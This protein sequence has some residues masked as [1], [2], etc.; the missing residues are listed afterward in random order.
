MTRNTHARALEIIETDGTGCERKQMFRNI[1]L[2]RE[3]RKTI[4][5]LAEVI[6]R[7][8]IF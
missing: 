6:F 4:Q 7:R 8:L 1:F 3:K 5:Y 2:H